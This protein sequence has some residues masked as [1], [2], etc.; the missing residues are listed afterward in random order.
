MMIDFLTELFDTDG[1]PPRWR[2]GVWSDS[3]GWLHIVSD[4]AIFGAYV[5]IP[6]V[7]AFFTLRRKDIPFPRVIWLFV[8]FIFACGAT[9]LIDAIIFWQPVYRFAGVVKLATAL[10]SWGTVIALVRIVPQVLHLPGLAK[11]NA[12]LCREVEDRKRIEAELR[13][14]EAEQRLAHESHQRLAAE[15]DELLRRLQ[16]QIE[17]MPVA[18][19]LFDAELR[20]I[21]WNP[22]AERIFGYLKEEIV[23][24]GP[25]YAKI[26]PPAEQET[27]ECVLD[28]LRLGEMTTHSANQNLT[29]DGRII[30]CEWINTRLESD[31]GE[32]DGLVSLAQDA[33][34]RISMEE[35][36]RQTL[37]MEAIGKLAGGVAHDF[38]N[39]L[40]IILGYSAIIREECAKDDALRVAVD[41]I[42]KAA[43]QA[44]G[45]TRQLL[46]FSR[47]Q[48]LAPV[49][50]DLNSRLADMEN[51]LRRLIGED[52]NLIV[53]C[54]KNLWHVRVDVGQMEQV[55]MNLVVNS[56]D[57]MPQG[58]TLTIETTNVELDEQYATAQLRRGQVRTYSWR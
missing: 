20:V 58:G 55:I 25:P 33:T 38:N 30:T 48:V 15:R 8:A 46:A 56:R 50:L 41:E 45:L 6:S 9:H 51:M 43:D 47:K 4:L 57:A 26:V 35:Q 7:L 3:L 5:A 18:Y 27:V 13:Q 10:C 37:K 11:L 44:A 39:L 42:R 2:C 21:D 53:R 12:D 22:A 29:K 34:E 49:T 19:M 28:R 23:G 36:L 54:A 14:S 16:L 31:E 52:V 32:F 24:L 1:F 17:S 40:T